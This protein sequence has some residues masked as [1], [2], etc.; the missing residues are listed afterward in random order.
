MARRSPIAAVVAVTSVA[1]LGR[2]AFVALELIAELE[3]RGGGGLAMRQTGAGGG[4]PK[5]VAALERRRVGV[6]AKPLRRADERCD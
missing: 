6:D 1:A 4:D 5:L 2:D 3:A